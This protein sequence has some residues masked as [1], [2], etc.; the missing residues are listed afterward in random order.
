MTKYTYHYFNV[1]GRGEVVRLV[2]VA[3]GVDFDDRR[4]EFQ[5][6]PKVKPTTPTGQLPI[7]EIDGKKYFQSISLARYIAK[8]NGLAGTND[9][10]Q[11]QID[12]VVD[13][14]HDL[15][16]EM[17]VPIF[18]KDEKRKAE[19][20]KKLMEESIPR[21]MGFLSKTLK[22]NGG[23]YF[24]GKKLSLADIYFFDVV[25]RF[26]EKDDKVLDKFPELKANLN[27]TKSLPK[28]ADYLTKRPKTDL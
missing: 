10:E 25:S 26:L 7:L 27:K 19:Q 4:I 13:N 3:A 14:V 1:K 18:E 21:G 15:H 6:W 22:D 11:L 9:L 5:D 8:K 23:Q 20:T 17:I 12:Q 28:I 24:V 16:E 2:F